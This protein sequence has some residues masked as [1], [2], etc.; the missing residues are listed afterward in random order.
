M[1]MRNV[2]FVVLI[3]AALLVNTYNAIGENAS[4]TEKIPSLMTPYFNEYLTPTTLIQLLNPLNL[5]LFNRRD[6]E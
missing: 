1:M 2:F 6:P 5:T 4:E 3:F